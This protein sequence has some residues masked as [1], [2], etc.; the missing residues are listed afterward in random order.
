MAPSTFLTSPASLDDLAW[1]IS[2]D[3]IASHTAALRNVAISARREG[4]GAALVGVLLDPAA[5]AVARE[6]AF[7][8]IAVALSQPLVAGTA[9]DRSAAFARSAA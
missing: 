1:A 2:V 6:R 9:F 8:M 4:V 7:G 5:P 3:G